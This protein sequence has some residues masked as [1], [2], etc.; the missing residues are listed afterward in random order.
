MSISPDILPWLKESYQSHHLSDNEFLEML[1]NQPPVDRYKERFKQFYKFNKKELDLYEG[2]IT[3]Y[4][5]SQTIISLKIRFKNIRIS[6]PQNQFGI[7]VNHFN[8]TLENLTNHEL[9]ELFTLINTCG[10]FITLVN[11]LSDK[12]PVDE[13]FHNITPDSITSKIVE[14]GSNG[15]KF[16]IE[17]KFDLELD[18]KFFQKYLYHFSPKLFEDRIKKHGLVPRSQSEVASYPDRI[19]LAGNEETGRKYLYPDL[20]AQSKRFKSSPWVLITIDPTKIPDHQK[21]FKDPNYSQGVYT[22]ANITP[23]AIVK[24]EDLH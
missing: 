3:T 9:K 10:W 8:I 6:R 11:F 17:A 23:Y 19:Y 15:L 24:I 4:P 18:R 16:F 2:L 7:E 20:K 14:I 1:E 5:I 12:K 22:L 13:I 21:F